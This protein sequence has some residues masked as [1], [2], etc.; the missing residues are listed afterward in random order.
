LLEQFG[1]DPSRPTVLYAP[2]WSP[3]SSL[4]HLG[5][6]F[7]ERLVTMPINV[8]VKLHDRSCDL[9][10]RYSGGVDWKATLGPILDRPNALLAT[11]A[12]ITPC[13]VAAD[14]MVTDHSS[15]GFEYLLLDRPLVR[16]DMPQLI[17]LA[18]VHPDYVELLAGTAHNV[19]GADGAAAAAAAV[20]RALGD[21]DALSAS[22]Q[23]VAADLF[24][25]PGTAA[26][27]CA[28]ALYDVLGLAAHPSVTS[29]LSAGEPCLR[30]A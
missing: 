6:A 8:I 22:R 18:N 10:A 16:I 26:A 9:R 24:Y 17:E 7:V 2:T 20:E 28:A 14:V 30:S 19:R 29:A 4:N 5:V 3:A 13:L 21:P 11:S 1:L 23:A 27:R 25:R 15:C 12:N